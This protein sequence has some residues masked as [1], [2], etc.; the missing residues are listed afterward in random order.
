MFTF[1][2]YECNIGSISGQEKLQSQSRSSALNSSYAMDN[3][4]NWVDF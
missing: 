4:K 2:Q 3:N 1:S